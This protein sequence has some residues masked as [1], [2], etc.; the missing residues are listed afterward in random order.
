MGETLH[1]VVT[2][3]ARFQREA[4]P[5]RKE[6]FGTLAKGQSPAALMVACAD[7]RVDP[8][9]ITQT[10]PGQLFVCRNA[11]NIVPPH[12]SRDDGMGASIEYAVSVLEI[13]HIIVCGHSDCGAMKGARAPESLDALPQVQAWLEHARAANLT[14]SE[15]AD[16]L[17]EDETLDRLIE[18]NTLLQL[19]HLRT[20]PY[21]AS[22]LASARLTLHAWVYDIGSGRVTCYDDTEGCFVSLSEHAS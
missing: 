2:G 18:Q 9:L 17:S 14:V 5:A 16:G 15:Q 20:H 19:A 3:V 1:E 6:L 12:G 21:V 7:S 4:Y 22:R 10:A 8:A 13:E 11:G